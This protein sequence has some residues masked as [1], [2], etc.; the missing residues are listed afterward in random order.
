MKKTIYGEQ[1]VIGINSYYETKENGEKWPIK[2]LEGT[3]FKDIAVAKNVYTGYIHC[4]ALDIDGNLWGW[5]YAKH[6]QFGTVDMSIIKE[7]QIVTNYKYEKIAAFAHGSILLSTSGSVYVCGHNSRG[8]LGVGTTSGNYSLT[9]I[10]Y[11]EILDIK[12]SMYNGAILY[13]NGD[14]YVWGLNG[15]GQ[16]GLGDKE[17]RGSRTL[18][19]TTVK[20]KDIEIGGSHSLAIDE[21]GKLW[22]WGNGV[23]YSLGNGLRENSLV[24]IQV[25]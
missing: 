8:E 24:P 3:K 18:L 14:I 1:E 22:S 15:S 19:N 7:P 23:D 13:K 9:S 12:G 20:F 16:L 21:N 17:N 25:F 5:G 4:L 2:I 6:G 11:G 10:A